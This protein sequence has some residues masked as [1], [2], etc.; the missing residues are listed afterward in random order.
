MDMGGA[1]LFK[2]EGRQSCDSC[3]FVIIFNGKHFKNVCV[4]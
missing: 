1:L 3:L 4:Y 2:K